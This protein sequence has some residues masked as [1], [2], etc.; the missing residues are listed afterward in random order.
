MSKIFTVLKFGT[1]G[2]SPSDKSPQLVAGTGTGS[3]D[4]SHEQFTRRVL[5]NKSRGLVPKIPETGLNSWD[6]SRTDQSWSMR[7]DLKKKLP[8]HTMEPVHAT[9]CR[10]SCVS[11]FTVN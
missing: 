1:H 11:P 6:Y 7:L 10:D 9:S 8:V 2:I 3:K 4:L 5:R